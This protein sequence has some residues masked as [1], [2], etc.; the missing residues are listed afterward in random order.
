MPD[1]CIFRDCFSDTAPNSRVVCEPHQAEVDAVE[2]RLYGCGLITATDPNK[3]PHCGCG[4]IARTYPW[5]ARV[6]R[7]QRPS[8]ECGRV[9]AGGD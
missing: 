4:S 6:Y 9:F 7:C 1:R 5:A 2:A 8:T 3:C